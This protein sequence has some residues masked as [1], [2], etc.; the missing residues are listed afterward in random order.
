MHKDTLILGSDACVPALTQ[1][2]PRNSSLTDRQSIGGLLENPTPLEA[3]LKDRIHRHPKTDHLYF[4]GHVSGE[5]SPILY[6]PPER[7]TLAGLLQLLR[8]SPFMH[9]IVDCASNPVFDA[10]TLF[11]LEHSDAVVRVLTPDIKG[12]EF[13]K[14]QLAWMENGEN[15]RTDRHLKVANPILEHTP[16]KE[17]EALF[18]AFDFSLPYTRQVAERTMA[19]ELLSSMDSAPGL[20]F[21]H[22]V[23]ALAA[24]IDK[25]AGQNE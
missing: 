11:A 23:A 24:R 6:R 19:G 15:F 1:Y 16:V 18:G 7:G 22:T 4:M 12:Y 17:A 3:G 21:E 10:V 14:A 2:L 13:Q 9:V 25:E 5:L 20:R 8:L